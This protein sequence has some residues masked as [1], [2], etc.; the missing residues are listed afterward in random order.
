MIRAQ[1]IADH[2]N[3]TGH[4]YQTRNDATG[5]A[6]CTECDW[7]Y[8]PA[9]VA[10]I[11]NVTKSAPRALAEKIAELN[12]GM[13]VIYKGDVIGTTRH[14]WEQHIIDNPGH[15]VRSE[16]FGHPYT[17]DNCPWLDGPET[18]V[19][20][21][22]RT[23]HTVLHWLGQPSQCQHDG[24]PWEPPIAALVEADVPTDPEPA[25]G[26]TDDETTDPGPE[27]EEPT[28]EPPLTLRDR[29]ANLIDVYFG[30]QDGNP[31]L[32]NAAA[33]A[34]LTDAIHKVVAAGADYENPRIE[35]TEI[36]PAQGLAYLLDLPEWGR[37][38]RL[39][40]LMEQARKGADC[41]TMD[42]EGMRE[43]FMALRKQRDRLHH[44]M[45]QIARI[46]STIDQPESVG[47]SVIGSISAEALVPE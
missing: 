14:V 40:M 28:P 42:H 23:G 21:A 17:C 29:I 39:G 4:Q 34:D 45:V 8:P 1:A 13:E 41:F 15:T 12:P 25:M 20:H 11:M 30:M 47:Q 16:G 35:N 19:A 3:A 2:T 6:K 31:G 5:A 9:E 10:G 44:A 32:P 37:V 38:A 46:T 26:P 24:C 36:T 7:Q 18:S 27:P 33:A 43:E 22:E